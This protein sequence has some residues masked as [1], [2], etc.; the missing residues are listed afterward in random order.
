MQAAQTSSALCSSLIL[1][2]STCTN[3]PSKAPYAASFPLSRA[4]PRTSESVGEPIVGDP[5][6]RIGPKSRPAIDQGQLACS[7]AGDSIGAP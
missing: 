2:C 3:C 4:G 5:R 7:N 6:H 1:R